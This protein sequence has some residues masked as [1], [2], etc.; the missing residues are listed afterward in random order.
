MTLLKTAAVNTQLFSVE[1]SVLTTGARLTIRPATVHIDFVS[2]EE[3]V[4]AELSTVNAGISTAIDAR[5]TG[6]EL[7]IEADVTGRALAAA[8]DPLL[9]E[10]LVPNPVLA[11]VAGLTNRTAAIHELLAIVQNAVK[12]IWTDEV[13]VIKTG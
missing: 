4:S 1:E 12:A 6:I 13:I 5:L 9:T 8:V 11:G 2:V 7:A 3:S 10:H